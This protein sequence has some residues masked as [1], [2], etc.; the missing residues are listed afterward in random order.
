MQDAKPATLPPRTLAPRR[1]VRRSAT[2]ILGVLTVVYLLGGVGLYFGQGW[3]MF[4]GAFIHDRRDATVPPGADREIITIHDA[5]GN[6]VTAVFGAAQDPEGNPLPDFKTRPTLLYLYGNGDCVATSMNL[7][8][9]FRRLGANVM[10]PEYLGYPMSSGRPGE[11]AFYDTADA[12][13]SYLVNRT[14]VDRSQIIVVG[15]SIGSGPAIDLAARKAVAG[16]ATFSG[17]TSMDEMAQKIIPFY[18]TGFLCKTHFQNWRKIAEVKCP[19]FLAHGTKDD[20][21]PY[22][23]MGRLAAQAKVAVSV[24][25]VEGADHNDIFGVGGVEL[26]RK[27]GQFITSVHESHLNPAR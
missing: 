11:Q 4:P 21:V 8:R 20:F 12:A 26:M 2:R 15:R 9:R 25:P 22:A 10:I 13:Y 16:V 3:M 23:M 27:F 7:F 19:V 14:G 18:P 6:R 24:V 17:F 1:S 5:G